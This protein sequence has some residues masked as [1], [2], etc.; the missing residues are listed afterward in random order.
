M[1]MQSESAM[2]LVGLAMGLLSLIVVLLNR[3]KQRNVAELPKPSDVVIALISG[4]EKIS[5][6]RSYR[7]QTGASLLEASRVI[8]ASSAINVQR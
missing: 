1:D 3:P 8:D 4:G 2:L 7:K 6:I 5:A